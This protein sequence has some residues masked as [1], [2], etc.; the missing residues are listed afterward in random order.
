MR[1]AASVVGCEGGLGVRRRRFTR[2]ESERM[3]ARSDDRSAAVGPLRALLT[4][5][6]S[7]LLCSCSVYDPI[8][9]ARNEAPVR[10]GRGG[11]SA[12]AGAG[13]SGGASGSAG[14]RP[15]GSGGTGPVAGADGPDVVELGCGDGR[16]SLN[17]KCDIAIAAG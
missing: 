1:W 7:C 2:D 15:G 16:V 4:A 5:A 13:G 9:V 17:E 11:G 10:A 6:L 8:K 3:A 14:M 12:G